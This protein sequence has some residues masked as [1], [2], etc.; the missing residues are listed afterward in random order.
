MIKNN[1][2]SVT[3]CSNMIAYIT[4]ITEGQISL[5]PY[6]YNKIGP[7]SAIISQVSTPIVLMQ[8]ERAKL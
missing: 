4:V 8:E 1:Y 5:F 3:A 2:C 7:I 6:C